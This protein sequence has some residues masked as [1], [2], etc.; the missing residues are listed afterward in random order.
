MLELIYRGDEVIFDFPKGIR[1]F[2]NKSKGRTHK[3][4]QFPYDFII[5]NENKE[6][7]LSMEFQ[8][9]CPTQ[10][11]LKYDNFIKKTFKL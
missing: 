1:Y 2:K 4:V 5:N 7:I 9:I 11:Y 6:I 8:D 10:I 3:V